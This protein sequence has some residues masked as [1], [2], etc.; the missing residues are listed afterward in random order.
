MDL[1][2]TDTWCRL[3]E[4]CTKF[5]LTN[6]FGYSITPDGVLCWCSLFSG[7]VAV[8]NDTI[9]VEGRVEGS[10]SGNIRLGC[11]A[12]QM[13]DNVG[14]DVKNARNVVAKILLERMGLMPRETTDDEEDV[15]RKFF[16]D[17]INMTQEIISS[18]MGKN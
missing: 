8:I 2:E 6:K 4:V 12:V 9:F 3:I 15:G 17:V 5:G 10:G 11:C 14:C 13:C 18:E 7:N 1:Q 16:C